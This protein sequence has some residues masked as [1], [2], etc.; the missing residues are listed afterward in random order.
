MLVVSIETWP[1]QARMVLISTPA[2]R[3]WVAVVCL[4]EC[5]LT[6]F[7]ARSMGAH[8]LQLSSPAH[9]NRIR[10]GQYKLEHFAVGLRLWFD[11]Q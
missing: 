3:R 1:S 11:K 7:V 9:S 10:R 4:S 8:Q 2:R 6:R 5:G